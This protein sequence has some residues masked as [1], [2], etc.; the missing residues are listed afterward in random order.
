M[1][2]CLLEINADIIMLCEV[3]GAESLQNFND[4]FLKSAY[5]PALIEGN[6][7]R[8][9]DV[10]F[11]IK[12]DAPFYFDLLSNKNRLINYLYPHERESQANGYPLKSSSHKFSRDAV[13]LRLFQNNR[14]NPF[15]ILLLTHLKSRLDKDRVDPGGFERRQ[16]E[17]RTLVEIYQELDLKHPQIPKLVCG[18]FNGNAASVQTDEE[19]RPL[20]E[21]T[22]LR[23]VLELASVPPTDRWTFTQVRSGSRS[24]GRQIDFSF[25]DP[26]AAAFIQKGDAYVYR[27]KNDR[28][29]EIDP[30]QSLEAKAVLP[31]DHYP[32]VFQLKGLKAF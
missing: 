30:P 20:Y 17:L 3:G 28:G 6:S 29:I 26:L 22:L 9:I 31:S 10:G 15:C 1:A 23:D 24:E 21:E 19:F 25:L 14:E 18:D 2:R 11:L 32:L 12:K 4:L 16:A 8:N 27:Y 5:T 13:E 7:D